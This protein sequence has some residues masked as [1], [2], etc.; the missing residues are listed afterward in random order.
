MKEDKLVRLAA[1]IIVASVVVPIGLGIIGGV[2]RTTYNQINKIKYNHKIK[3]GLKNG[4]IIKVDDNYYEVEE[5][6]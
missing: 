1:G 5:S 3:K 2:A 6:K 4:T